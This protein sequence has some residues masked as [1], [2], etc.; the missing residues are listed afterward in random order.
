LLSFGARPLSFGEAPVL[1]GVLTRICVRA[2]L[3]SVPQ[4][5][6][7]PMS[8]MN[9]YA[10]GS[11]EDA[12]ISVTEG[13]L[14]GLSAD[15][16]A[17]IFAHEVAHIR[18]RDSGA[19]NWARTLIDDVTNAALN[20]LAAASNR[21]RAGCAAASRDALLMASVPA[22][23]RLLYSALSRVRELA[24]DSMAIDMIDDPNALASALCKLE[25]YHSGMTPLDAHLLARLHQSSLTSSMNSHPGTWERLSH[26]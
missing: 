26:M 7:L 14:R 20:G 21:G 12:C 16:V 22:V 1:Y 15:E 13:L 9:A 4:L 19:M 6:L 17:G 23:A 24:A 8:G 5:F 11:P 25:F 2:G 10:L 3:P 18:E